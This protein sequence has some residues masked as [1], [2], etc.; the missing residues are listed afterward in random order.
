MIWRYIIKNMEVHNK[1]NAKKQGN[2]EGIETFR[3]QW[4]SD[5]SVRME[6]HSSQNILCTIPN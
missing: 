6:R 3:G 4:G 5:P 2:L 1:E